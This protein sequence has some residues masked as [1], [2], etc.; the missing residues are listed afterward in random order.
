LL[1]LKKLTHNNSSQKQQGNNST[2][3]RETKFFERINIIFIHTVI[4][5]LNLFS[6]SFDLAPAKATDQAGGS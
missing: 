6:S 2:S 5:E 4:K 1:L 3:L